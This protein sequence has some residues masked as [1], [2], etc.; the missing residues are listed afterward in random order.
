MCQC[1]VRATPISTK[2]NNNYDVDTEG[3]NA[4]GRATLI[5]TSLERGVTQ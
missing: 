2:M 1:L 3:V 5:S 4:L